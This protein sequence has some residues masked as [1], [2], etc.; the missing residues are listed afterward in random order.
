VVWRAFL[1]SEKQILSHNSNTTNDMAIAANVDRRSAATPHVDSFSP[2][3]P[4]LIS[5]FTVKHTHAKTI[6]KSA[7]LVSVEKDASL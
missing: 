1:A 2:H 7:S 5:T 6:V 3:L 4:Q